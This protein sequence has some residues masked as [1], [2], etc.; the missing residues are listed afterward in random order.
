MDGADALGAWP[1]HPDLPSFRTDVAD[2]SGHITQVPPKLLQLV[3]AV[4]L[5]GFL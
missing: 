3:S 1:R 2:T 5:Q 4:W